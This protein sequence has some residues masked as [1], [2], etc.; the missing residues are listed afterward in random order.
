MDAEL[1]NGIFSVVLAIISLI[2]TTGWIINRK[3]R[4]QEGEGM[5][6][7]VRQKYLTCDT[8]LV[9]SFRDLVS[10]PIEIEVIKLRKEVNQLRD[11]IQGIYDCPYSRD[12]P[13]RERLRQQQEDD[14]ED[15]DDR[16][17]EDMVGC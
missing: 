4:K 14:G 3:Q 8:D 5:K 12:C 1:I 15:E 6:V 13:V 16:D 7:D 17:E 10:K 11:A 2:A 9:R